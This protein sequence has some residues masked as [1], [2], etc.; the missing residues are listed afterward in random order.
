MAIGACFSTRTNTEGTADQDPRY[1]RPKRT[2]RFPPGENST[3]Q[4]TG[5]TGS[6]V[7][8]TTRAR[9]R[10][11]S[12]ASPEGGS[13]ERSPRDPTCP[14]N[15]DSLTSSPGSLRSPTSSLQ[16]EGL[17]VRVRTGPELHRPRTT[18]SIT[19]GRRRA[20][21]PR[22]LVGGD[23]RPHRQGPV[24]PSRRPTGPTDRDRRAARHPAVD[25]RERDRLRKDGSRR[26]AVR[27]AD[28]R[29]TR[30]RPVLR[31]PD[32]SRGE[33]AARPN[34][35]GVAEVHE[36]GDRGRNRPRRASNSGRRGR[37]PR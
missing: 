26:A 28:A 25:P 18:G 7:T 1:R 30:R 11:G 16:R 20:V 32:T 9:R 35:E 12:A 23:R 3:A 33:A 24:R 17:H 2:N 37:S 31:R 27:R 15:R 19:G 5:S 8:A 10:L 21:S 29:R 6:R 13:P 14:A 22:L 36:R 4:P 34:R